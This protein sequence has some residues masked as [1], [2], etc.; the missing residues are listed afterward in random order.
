LVDVAIFQVAFSQVQLATGCV[1]LILT[2]VAY[3]LQKTAELEEPV[4]KPV[5]E[6]FP[7]RNSE[8]PYYEYPVEA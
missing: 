7:P 2:A 3:C 5:K 1:I 8:Q 4:T 6:A